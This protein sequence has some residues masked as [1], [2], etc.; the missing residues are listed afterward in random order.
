MRP[1]VTYWTA[2]PCGPGSET[3]SVISAS[4]N[5]S[6]KKGRH[7]NNFIRLNKEA[8]VG[9]QWWLIFIGIWNGISIFPVSR[10]VVNLASDASGS[11]RCGA[12]SDDQWFQMEWS[13][14][15]IQKDIAF[16]ELLSIVLAVTA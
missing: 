5:L 15:C 7:N 9:K 14:Q 13:A 12:Y 10:P 8:R 11:W 6:P 1:E 3:W 2:S 16:K 4:F